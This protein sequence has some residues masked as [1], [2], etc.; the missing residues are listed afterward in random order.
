MEIE[1]RAYDDDAESIQSAHSESS[2][3]S[4]DA[5]ETIESGDVELRYEQNLEYM[6][7]ELV[8]WQTKPVLTQG[9]LKKET[10]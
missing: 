7:E 3:I 6:E 10:F 1:I 8:K 5:E 2:F 9:G 4:V